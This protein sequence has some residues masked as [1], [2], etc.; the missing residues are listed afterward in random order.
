MVQGGTRGLDL[1]R[2]ST[3]STLPVVSPMKTLSS[4]L[5]RW[6]LAFVVAASAT[7][8][9]QQTTA[10][11]TITGVVRDSAQRPVAGADVVAR[12]GSHRTRT[13]SA[14]R[15]TFSDLGPDKY[16][17]RARKLGFAPEE[18]D[19]ALSK[20]GRADIQLILKHT[21]PT[22][23]TVVVRADREC[24]RRSLDGF[25]CRRRSGYGVFLDYTDIDDRE[26]LWTADLFRDIKGFRAD[27]RST[28]AG[29]IRVAVHQLPW[30]CVSHLVD[31]RPA[32]AANFVPTDPYELVALE[33]Y[34]RPDSVP[35]EYQEYTWPTTGN[36]TRS[37][38]CSVIVYWTRYARLTPR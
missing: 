7:A 8:T 13:D 19:V 22:L 21:M 24:S 27:V 31:G 1:A 2:W 26:P 34:A 28:R 36:I 4:S 3:T 30:G 38:R 35:K 9:A 37:G 17:V 32:S 11:G 29:P 15:F 10:G 25:T 23:D 18:W 20:N 12:P 14:G 16:V 5:V 6:G 33:V